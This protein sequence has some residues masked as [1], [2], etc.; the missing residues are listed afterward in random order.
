MKKGRLQAKDVDDRE[1]LRVIADLMAA[2]YRERP[3]EDQFLWTFRWDIE[4]HFPT[5]PERVMKAKYEA[6]ARRG[7]IDGC[8]CGCRGDFWVTPK[9]RAVLVQSESGGSDG[10]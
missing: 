6:L 3:Y 10:K 2:A 7:L 8:T 4:K 5:V 9:G 1:V